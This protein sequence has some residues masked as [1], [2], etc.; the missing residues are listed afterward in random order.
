MFTN[1]EKP[2]LFKSNQI[3]E[4][5]QLS[6]YN[7]MFMIFAIVPGIHFKTKKILSVKNFGHGFHP[8]VLMSELFYFLKLLK[9]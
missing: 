4:E 6:R 2:G 1:I 3:F 9:V 7:C 8:K 5:H